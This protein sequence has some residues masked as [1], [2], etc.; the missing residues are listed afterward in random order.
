MPDQRP[1]GGSLGW[2]DARRRAV[3]VR[4]RN[5]D[6]RAPRVLAKG[7]GEIAERIIALARQHGIPLH[8]DRDLVHLLGLIELD[9]EI[10]PALYRALAEILAHLYRA[11]ARAGR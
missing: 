11:N 3:A 1:A 6:D 9:T 5:D 4:Y 2:D 8:E 10:P 7:G